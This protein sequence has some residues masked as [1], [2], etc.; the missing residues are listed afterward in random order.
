MFNE[1]GFTLIELLTT[2]AII[3]VLLAI[4]VPQYSAYKRRAFDIRAASD[5]RNVASAEEAYFMDWEAY[6]SCSNDSCSQLPGIHSLSQGV[7]LE[8]TA[9][10]DSFQG[11]ARHEKG[12]GRTY[13]WDSERGGMQP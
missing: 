10:E 12:T 4:A 7:T 13:N 6:L 11:S 1:N 8:I 3:G 5:L 2:M 9:D